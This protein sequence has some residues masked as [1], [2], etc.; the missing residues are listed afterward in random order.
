MDDPISPTPR[1]HAG[2][3]FRTQGLRSAALG[4]A[5]SAVAQ[6]ASAAIIYDLAVNSSTGATF[7][8]DGSAAGEIDL[9]SA[10]MMTTNLYLEGPTGMGSNSTVQ[11]S[12]FS[13]GGGMFSTNYLTLLNAGDTVDGS[14]TYA[15]RSYMSRFSNDNPSWPAG[16]TGYAGFVFDNGSGPFYGWL[17]LQFDASGTDFTVLQ[18][19]YDDTGAPI[20]AAAV[21]EPGT[22][23]L[24]GFGL[25]GLATAL[26]RRR[27]DA[28]R[29]E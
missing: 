18:W 24:L 20:A 14:L 10:G 23:V 19:A 29:G 1:L 21:P 5:A 15:S 25:A 2:N 17:Q 9:V 12:V 27:S 16:T 28:R 3:R 7:S 13:T 4:L 8:V 11:L 22:A 26:R 6:P